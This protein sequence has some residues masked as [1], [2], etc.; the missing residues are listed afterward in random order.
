MLTMGWMTI[1]LIWCMILPIHFILFTKTGIQFAKCKNKTKT[2]YIYFF[3]L[4]ITML[5]Y[6]FSFVDAGDIGTSQAIDFI[7]TDILSTISFVS[8]LINIV[9]IFIISRKVKNNR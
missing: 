9:L 1:I 6:A 8:F 2:S 7:D 5:L 4:C 3:V